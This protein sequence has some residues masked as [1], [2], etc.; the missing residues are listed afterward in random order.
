MNTKHDDAVKKFCEGYNC[1][2]SVLFAH[3]D[4]LHLDK[5]SALRLATGFGAGMGRKEEVCGAVS[6]GILVLGLKHGR[7]EK[8]DRSATETTY[9]RTRELMDKFQKRHGTFICKQLLNGIDL[10]TAE[11][12]RS[13]KENDFLNRVCVPCVE[14][15]I[16]ILEEMK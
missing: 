3:C 10:T 16:T 1:A 7:G 14:S 4:A 5:N 13:F 11:G 12:Q 2:Q 6:G 9:A 15:V 8:D